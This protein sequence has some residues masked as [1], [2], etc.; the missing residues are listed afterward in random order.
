M[1]M[2]WYHLKEELLL[3]KIRLLLWRNKLPWKREVQWNTSLILALAAHNWKTKSV[4][5]IFFIIIFGK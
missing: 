2:I 1:T 3:S 4:I 5:V